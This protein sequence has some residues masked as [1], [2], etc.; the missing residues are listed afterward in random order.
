MGENPYKNFELNKTNIEI[1]R[2]GLIANVTSLHKRQNDVEAFE[3]LQVTVI[4]STMRKT[5][6]TQQI[7][8]DY[9]LI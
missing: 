1:G 3:Q 4:P 8:K 5:Q 7:I 9:Y 6:T 2:C